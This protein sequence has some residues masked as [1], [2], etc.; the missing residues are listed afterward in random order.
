MIGMGGGDGNAPGVDCKGR[1]G[2]T[3]VS[4]PE[5]ICCTNGP[6]W[7]LLRELPKG[8]CTC[9]RAREKARIERYM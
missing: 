8:Y 3:T 1:V 7:I 9:T 4:L 5:D 6:S 2:D